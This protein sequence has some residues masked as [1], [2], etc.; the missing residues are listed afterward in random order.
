MWVSSWK[1]ENG[2]DIPMKMRKIHKWKSTNKNRKTIPKSDD[3]FP[4][5]FFYVT[6]YTN[7][8]GTKIFA[9]HSRVQFSYRFS[10]SPPFLLYNIQIQTLEWN[11]RRDMRE[12]T[13]WDILMGKE[14]N[15]TIYACVFVLRCRWY[16]SDCDVLS[17]ETNSPLLYISKYKRYMENWYRKRQRG[18]IFTTH[19]LTPNINHH[20][21]FKERRRRKNK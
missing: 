11:T 3:D 5:I 9:T 21:D 13:L 17:V 12:K 18:L 1:V 20:Q 6:S 10:F 2:T 14:K 4:S 8:E 7:I 16:Y 19:L 15:S